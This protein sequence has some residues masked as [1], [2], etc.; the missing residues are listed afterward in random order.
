MNKILNY[1]N[2]L[3]ENLKFDIF[4]DEEY[5]TISLSGIGKI[6]LKETFPKYE[7]LDDIGYEQ[8]EKM[9]IDEYDLITKIEHIEINDE[10]KN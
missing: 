6:I 9:G 5:T 4:K 8:L 3:N 7:F 2:Y 10:Y 1:I